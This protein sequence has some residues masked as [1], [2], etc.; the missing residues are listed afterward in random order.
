MKTLLDVLNEA[1][2]DDEYNKNW[3]MIDRE[4]FDKI[5]LIDPKTTT[6]N[7][8]LKSIGF[9][10]KQFLLPK[11]RDG[12]V[13]FINNVD[14]VN[15]AV[16]KY[17]LNPGQYAKLTAFK[18]VDEF[19]AYID[20]P[21]AV[22][23]D[24]QIVQE[25]DPITTIYNKYYSDIDRKDFDIII[26][27]DPKTD[28]KSI[29]EIAKNLLL[30][31][32]RKKENIL[33]K[34]AQIKEACKNYY[35]YKNKLPIEKQQLTSYESVQEFVD[36]IQN[37][38]ESTLVA[39]LKKDETIDPK[40]NQPV[41]QDFKIIASTFDYD[42][43]EPLS[44]KAAIVISGGYNLNTRMQWC[45]GWAPDRDGEND[46]YW[47]RYTNNGGRVICFMHKKNYRG[48]NNRTINWQIHVRDNQI[49]EFL[50]GGD[51]QAFPGSTKP[52]QFKNFL[53]AQPEIF[54][55]IK[56]KDPFN[57]IEIVKDLELETKYSR[58]PFIVDNV[59][60]IAILETS[61]LSKICQEIIFDISK[62]PVGICASF[63]SLK[64]V[65][66]KEGVKEIGDQAF[67]SC[68]S[69]KT[70]VFP[71]SLEI[72]GREA[73]LNC[74]ELKGAVKIPDNV[75]EIRTRAFAQTSCKLKINRARKTKL[76]FDK[77]DRN[78]VTTHVQAITV[79]Q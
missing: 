22:I 49:L 3:S 30:I 60:K 79:K 21:D 1:K 17:Q 52:E 15:K 31:N 72:I 36:Y 8:E 54:I 74:L 75:K 32:Y 5:A 59:K 48:S 2:I 51:S 12:D 57:K 14:A 11:Y 34:T 67:M 29:G 38:P 39:E 42:I 28:E 56:T 26:A 65:I 68:P 46:T 7:N 78:W 10:A 35:A 43:L 58:E 9:V 37:G 70:I 61:D 69:I 50:N 77:T 73:F 55:A 23:I 6:E 33:E 63:L 40:T 24:N 4:I 71:E 41:K 18:T 13:E 64:S 25:V 47:N 62:I 16:I 20:N 45:T 76:K 53:I 27:L 66:F 19:V 44:H